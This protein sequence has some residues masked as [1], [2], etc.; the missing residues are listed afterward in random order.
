MNENWSTQTVAKLLN[1]HFSFFLD[2][3]SMSRAHLGRQTDQRDHDKI[4]PW[5]WTRSEK[6]NT[7]KSRHQMLRHIR[8]GSAKWKRYTNWI[9]PASII[10]KLTLILFFFFF[11][12]R[13]IPCLRFRWHK[14]PCPS[15]SSQGRQRIRDDIKD[16]CNPTEYYDWHWSTIVWSH[17]RMLGEFHQGKSQFQWHEEVV[18]QNLNLISC[19]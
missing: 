14:F 13:Q 18:Q 1:F 10:E 3:R 12:A 15:D 19:F 9:E 4:S 7:S 8:S 16:L 17:C 2:T 11:R 5:N 6:G